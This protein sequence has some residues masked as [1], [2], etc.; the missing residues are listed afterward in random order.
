MATGLGSN[1]SSTNGISLFPNDN[2]PPS[3]KNNEWLAQVGRA[4]TYRYAQGRLYFNQN[5]AARIANI[6]NYSNGQQS[7]SKYIDMWAAPGDEKKS[8]NSNLSTQ[9]ARLARKG[10]ANIS[11]D[12]FSIAPELMRVISALLTTKGQHVNV[13][14]LNKEVKNKRVQM[15]YELFLREKMRSLMEDI[16]LPIKEDYVRPRNE[17]ELEM[18]EMVGGFTM[19]FETAIKKI[20][21][22]TLDISDYYPYIENQLK[23]D[24]VN[25]ACMV[26][27]VETDPLSGATK[28]KY[29]DIARFTC[30]YVP[31]RMGKNTPFVGTWEKRSIPEIRVMLSQYIDDEEKV[32]EYTNK[33]AMSSYN[34]MSAGGSPGYAAISGQTWAWYNERDTA[35]G[36]W[37][38]DELFSDILF[39]EYITNDSNYYKKKSTENKGESFYQDEWGDVK[40]NDKKKTVV[41]S[42]AAIYEGFYIP[43]CDVAFGG[44]QKNMMFVDKK[45]PR[46]SYSIVPVNTGGKGIGESLIPIHDS[47]MIGHLR[48]QAAKLAARPKGI[49]IDLASINDMNL[50]GE[51]YKATDIIKVWSHTGVLFYRAELKRGNV[52]TGGLPMQEMENGI[53]KQ[54]TEWI[55][56]YADDI[57]K[58]LQ[59]SGITPIMAASPNISPEKAVGVANAETTATTNNLYPLKEALE[60]MKTEL[61]KS[62]ILKTL[63]NIYYDKSVRKYYED[64]L[65][66]DVVAELM[67]V[68]GL[69]LEELGIELTPSVSDLAKA[70]IMQAADKALNV[71]RN[72]VPEIEVGDKVFITQ[73]VENGRIEEAWRYLQYTS[74]E[75]RRVAEEAAAANAEA[76]AQRM[77]ELEMMKIEGD[78]VKAQK[79]AEIEVRKEA[80]LSKIRVE[81][82]VAKKTAIIAEQTEADKELLQVEAM[83]QLLTGKDTGTKI[84]INQQ[85]S[86]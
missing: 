8:P 44:K 4:I 58:A 59:I 72:G 78:I 86:N 39:F 38:Y 20:A 52:V 83:V 60:T 42:G 57:Q 56:A 34:T 30:A 28:I 51:T 80:V 15:K 62:A 74:A 11:F 54:L 67:L 68:Q 18:Y 75:R 84:P 61:S 17:V 13:K 32:E 31:Q 25:V 49:M 27:G 71:G 2:I 16:G 69:T 65:G 19:R 1:E 82:E 85:L 46:L 73:L 5:D 37:R 26:G 33:I 76:Q 24:G 77:K 66:E 35:T 40:N 43:A 6:R 23:A 7:A 81:E 48:L 53:G 70:E 41:I 29:V 12:I 36:R 14:S 45:T 47:I 79:L 50:G 63:V 9:G 10:Y 22:H 21:E 64:L 3:K 55:T